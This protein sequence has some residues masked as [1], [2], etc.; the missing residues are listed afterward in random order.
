VTQPQLSETLRLHAL[1]LAGD[2]SG[3]RANLTEANLTEANLTEANL[4]KADLTEAN[5][6]KA[7]LTEANLIEADLTEANLTKAK[8]PPLSILPEGT[9]IGWKKLQRRKIAKLSIPAEARRVNSTGRKCRC[10]FA[11]VLEVYPDGYGLGLYDN[12]PYKAGDRVV[13]DKYNP[14]FRVECS[15]GIHFFITRKEAEDY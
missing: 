3:V 11:D 5:L 15:G 7:D 2:L 10:E 9:F 13:A 4:T 14:D 8:L 12:T 6:T 1:W